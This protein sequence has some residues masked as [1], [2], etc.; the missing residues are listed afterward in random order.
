MGKL[1]LFKVAS[2]C[3]WIEPTPGSFA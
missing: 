1:E 2:M 3:T